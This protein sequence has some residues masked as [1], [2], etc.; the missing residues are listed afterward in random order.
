MR[1]SNVLLHF[2]YFS[3]FLLLTSGDAAG[4]LAR[5]S[6]VAI[7][8]AASFDQTRTFD[9]EDAS[10]VVVDGVRAS[11]SGAWTSSTAGGDGSATSGV[12]SVRGGVAGATRGTD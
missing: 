10:G 2:F 3:T 1:T 5:P 12:E 7:D 6:A 8:T 11:A 9:G 4:Q